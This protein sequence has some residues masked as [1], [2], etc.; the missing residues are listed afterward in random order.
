[1]WAVV[2]AGGTGRRFGGRKQYAELHGRSLLAW[3]VDAARAVADG[4]VVV[5][6]ADGAGAGGVD[7]AALGADAVVAGGAT[8]SDSVRAGLAAVP[9]TA[10]VVVVHDAARPLASA[11]LFRQVVEAVGAT[12][13]PDAAVP[14][15]PVADTVKRVAGGRVVATVPRD[16]LVT[17]Q[18]PQAFR[19]EALR[20]AHAGGGTATDDAGLVEALGL[21][22]AVVPGEATNLK[23]TTPGDLAL[24]TLLVVR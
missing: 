11:A 14:G 9:D 12:G 21:V 1:M 8:R 24:A 17:V 22:V 18:T 2:V 13:G 23:V 19:A 4:V 16:D 15:L 20:A 7:A 3:S 5:V 10:R 6:P